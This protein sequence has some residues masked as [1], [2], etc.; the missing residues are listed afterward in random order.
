MSATI[1]IAVIAF[2]AW[3]IYESESDN[4]AK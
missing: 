2:M 4:G 3:V 1:Y